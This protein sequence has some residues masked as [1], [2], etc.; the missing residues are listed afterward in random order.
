MDGTGHL[1]KRMIN[2]SHS[3]YYL[4][5]ITIDF[6]LFIAPL[7]PVYGDYVRDDLI[8]MMKNVLL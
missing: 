3:N 1:M 4:Y 2:C 8:F 5:K 7:S 6:F